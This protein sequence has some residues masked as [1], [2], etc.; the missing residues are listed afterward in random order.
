M[1]SLALGDLPAWPAAMT[2][3]EALSYT[4]VSKSQLDEWKV[5]GLVRF[6]L[7]GANGAA[8]APKADLD[9]ALA[10]L[11]GDNSAGAPIEFD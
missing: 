10:S 7:R 5:R 11:F 3:P 2:E 9:A 8:I 1:A 4:R 6:R